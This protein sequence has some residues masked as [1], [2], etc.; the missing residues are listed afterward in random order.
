MNEHAEMKNMVLETYD[1]QRCGHALAD[2]VYRKAWCDTQ[3]TSLDS[4]VGS[5][6]KNILSVA[7]T[8]LCNSFTITNAFIL[9]LSVILTV[10][11]VSIPTT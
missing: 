8:C 6:Y 10:C 7:V 5:S 1:C 3:T 9:P 4:E 11:E 2:G